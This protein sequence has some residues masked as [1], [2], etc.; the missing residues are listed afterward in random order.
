MIEASPNMPW[1]KG[2]TWF[3]RGAGTTLLEA[4][5]NIRPA[6]REVERPLRLP[7][8][9]VYKVG[10]IGTVP[11]GRVQTG[12]LKPGMAVTIAPT[13]ITTEVRSVE[14]HHERLVEAIPGDNV[15]FNVKN[16][17]VKDIK[18]GYVVGDL[19]N[20]PP[21]KAKSFIAQMIILNHPGEIHN[22]Y[23]PVLD[24]HTAHIACE[25]TE[26]QLKMDRQTG[27]VLE[28]NPKTIKSGDAAVILMTPSKPMVVE[29][30]TNYASLGRFAVRDMKQIVGVGVIRSVTKADPGK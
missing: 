29:A 27:K 28:E 30:F 16:V 11:V 1:F 10:G 2:W 6:K 14:M 9:N 4:I 25:F 12:I 20:D 5:D 13:N 26:I 3:P 15:G 7:I 24:C 18:R 19:E 22:G 8:Q 21:R 17:S 23:Q